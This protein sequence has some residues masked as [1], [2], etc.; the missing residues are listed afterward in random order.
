MAFPGMV[1]VSDSVLED[2]K[3]RVDIAELISSYGVQLKHAGSSIKACCPFHNEKTPSFSVNQAKGFYHCFGCGESGD[4][5][6]FVM[7]YEGLDFM[8]AVRKLAEQC[9]VKIEE[10]EDPEA[11]KRKRLF[12]LMA[13]LAQFYH[14][15]L[16]KMREA[17][18]A[19]DYLVGR[20]LG[21]DTQ[22]SFL[23]GYAPNGVSPIL[24]WAE[25]YG[26]TAA[27]LEAAGVIKLP[28]SPGDLG[29]HR[30]SGR[31]MFPVKDRQG[32]IVAFSGRQL[33]E[34]K[35]SGKYVNSPETAIF[36][37]SKVLFGFDRAA[38]KIAK[39]PHREAIICEGQIDTIRLHISGFPVAV[40]S[41]GT[42]FTDE[43]A[44]MLKTVAD[45]ALLVFDD[46]AA[47]HK[48]TI[49]TAAMLLA[50]GMPV[51]VVSLPGGEDPDSFLRKKGADEFQK[52]IDAA[53][54][55]VSFQCRVEAA[56]ER[57]PRSIDAVA[58]ISKAVLATIAAC[59]GA[60]L[61]ASMVDEAARLMGLPSA[62]LAEELEKGRNAIPAQQP[63]PV[64]AADDD[65]VHDTTQDDAPVDGGAMVGEDAGKAEPP[66]NR[67]MALMEFLLANESD[68]M[69]DGMIGEFLPAGVFTNDFTRRFIEAWRIDTINGD[70][71][72]A[73][74]ADSLSP[75]EHEWFDDIML[76]AGRTGAG[77]RAP[78]DI[79]QEFVRVLWRD[80]LMR[81]RGELPAVG[82]PD[83]DA[84]RLNISYA[85]KRLDLARWHEVKDIVRG[86]TIKGEPK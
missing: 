17:Q 13:E 82:D 18:I 60:V 64:A 15:C 84:E 33:V 23:I 44:K 61:R 10:R 6:K 42:S 40:A 28:S 56:K 11:G 48:A 85:L 8:S 27:E 54:S 34:R 58:R 16:G 22:D 14:R 72:L 53:E 21:E 74:F 29:Y 36:K 81:R 51:R 43:H 67:E 66:P 83:A 2:I 62:A 70:E 4:A 24:K 73:A 35:N 38:A 75:R 68:A 30:F 7:K 1:G 55:V 79:M 76:K 19:R 69:L 57:D 45:A 26:Y 78:S 25:K 5:I 59:P 50:A 77:G 41:Q 71:S 3:S 63:R 46:D 37:K 31:L 9:G 65:F 52:L 80:C 32:R 12:A 49:R 39:S 47:G 20:D 86:L